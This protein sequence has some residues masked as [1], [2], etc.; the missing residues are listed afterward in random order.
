MIMIIM[1]TTRTI[2]N[3][4]ITSKPY[5][6]QIMVAIYN[7]SLIQIV[8]RSDACILLA[9]YIPCNPLVAK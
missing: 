2:L 6:H 8:Q 4:N 7:E 3:N 9:Q 1:M 5:Y